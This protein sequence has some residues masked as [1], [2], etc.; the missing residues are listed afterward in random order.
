MRESSMDGI[1]SV[2]L[3]RTFEDYRGTD[4]W[5][6]PL[7]AEPN[8][9]IQ[10]YSHASRLLAEHAGHGVADWI[11]QLAGRLGTPLALA[12]ALTERD[13]G[14]SVMDLPQVHGGNQLIRLPE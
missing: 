3:N 6:C 7:G 14:T 1:P 4:E 13:V 9:P 8:G 12:S 2:G 10:R 11:D 5:A